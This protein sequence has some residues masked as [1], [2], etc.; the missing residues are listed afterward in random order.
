[1]FPK[2]ANETLSFAQV[3]EYWKDD[4]KRSVSQTQLI[5]TLAV[6][7]WKGELEASGT[8]RANVLRAIY[9]TGQDRLDFTCPDAPIPP[10]IRLPDGSVEVRPCIPVPNL[11]PASWL[12]AHCDEAFQAIASIWNYSPTVFE[13]E[14]PVVRSLLLK[15][16]VFTKWLIATGYQQQ[17]FWAHSEGKAPSTTKTIP[18]AE[19]FRRAPEHIASEKAAGRT[20]SQDGFEKALRAEGFRG[21]RPVIR[22]AYKAAAEK[23]Q[24]SVSRGRPFTR[25]RD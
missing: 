4:F 23:A 8:S 11:R 24:M 2:S 20:P 1:M 16:S 17:T 21:G 7:W 10:E 13:L 3:A 25:K 5:N 19:A 14:A 15:E 22:E 18:K 12:D 6:A 9:Q